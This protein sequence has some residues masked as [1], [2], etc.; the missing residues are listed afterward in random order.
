[1]NKHFLIVV[2]SL[3]TL[4]LFSIPYGVLGNINMPDAYILPSKMVEVSLTNYFVINGTNFSDMAANAE[5]Q[6]SDLTGGAENYNLAFS[7][8]VGLFDR[9]ELGLVATNYDM[10]YGNIKLK[11]YSE[12]EKF[13]AISVG[14]E[15]LF[16]KVAN[17]D[18]AIII[19]K[20]YNFTDPEDYIK[21]S[22]YIAMSKS[23]LLL[24]EVP[25]F[26]HLETTFHFGIGARRF[27]GQRSKVRN[28]HGA[29]GGID[30]KPSK[31][32]SING[33]IDSQNLNLGMNLYYKN[34]TIRACVYR[35]E[36]FFKEKDDVYY[37]NKFALGIKYTLDKYSEVKAAD[38]DRSTYQPT[39]SPRV[40]S[41]RRIAQGFTEAQDAG[42]V[43]EANPLLEELRLIRE[44]RKQAEKE[45]E[46]IRK[47]L[48][49]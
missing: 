6:T 29:F 34:F 43:Q 33:E 1:M 14:M 22:P 12:T 47:L 26:E 11:L 40:K 15:N 2:L 42:G 32:I 39:A 16:S 35:L 27:Q 37:G 5:A 8:S 17:S 49:E 46:E 21:N 45:L 38:K 44:R 20:D 25:Y 4:S 36:D 31:Y 18:S 19:N 28:L 3:F 9:L 23:T 41:K 10:M 13:P 24:T 48:K 30:L 7:A